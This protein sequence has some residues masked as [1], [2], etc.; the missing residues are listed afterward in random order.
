M[1]FLYVR[2]IWWSS[3]AALFVA[4]TQKYVQPNNQ[5][6]LRGSCSCFPL[7]DYSKEHD[8]KSVKFIEFVE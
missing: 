4:V 7:Q 2:I 6:T 8:S 5:K 3:L 1:L